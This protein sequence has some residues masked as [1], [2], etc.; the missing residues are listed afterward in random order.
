M[1]GFTFIDPPYLPRREW[2]YV[3]CKNCRSTWW[4]IEW[5][6]SGSRLNGCFLRFK[7]CSN[8]FGEETGFKDPTPDPVY[9]PRPPI[10]CEA[11]GECTPLLETFSRPDVEGAPILCSYCSQMRGSKIITPF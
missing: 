10:T 1:K 9:E 11:C 3:G 4:E 7:A 6:H 2:N 8:C 5:F